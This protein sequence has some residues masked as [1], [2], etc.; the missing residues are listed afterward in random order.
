MWYI[1][2]TEYYSDIKKNTVMPF[3]ATWMELEILT[4]GEASQ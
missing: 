1:Y 2:I 3:T 4:V